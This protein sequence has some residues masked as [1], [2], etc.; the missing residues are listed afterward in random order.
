M[1]SRPLVLWFCDICRRVNEA[2]NN[3]AQRM[4][5]RQ[6]RPEVS[7]ENSWL[8]ILE[9]PSQ[10]KR[11]HKPATAFVAGSMMTL[12]NTDP[13]EKMRDCLSRIKAFF[14]RH[15]IMDAHD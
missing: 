7:L 2:P 14:E 15:L 5:H 13:I 9:D 3:R 1:S 12:K 10:G 6:I 4:H 8:E 11:S